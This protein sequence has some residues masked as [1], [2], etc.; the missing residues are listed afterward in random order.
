MPSV[1]K[2]TKVTV[3]HDAVLVNDFKVPDCNVEIKCESGDLQEVIIHIFPDL[4]T[5]K[6]HGIDKK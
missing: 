1:D 5:I 4:V 6:Q 2:E 3:Y